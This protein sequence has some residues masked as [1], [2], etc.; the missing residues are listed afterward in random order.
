MVTITDLY[1]FNTQYDEEGNIEI[2]DMCDYPGESKNCFDFFK[3]LELYNIYK[4]G[5]DFPINLKH[6]S[7]T[8]TPDDE[9]TLKKYY[10]IDGLK[11]VLEENISKLKDTTTFFKVEISFPL[12]SLYPNL[13]FHFFH[14]L[15]NEGG[16]NILVN[17]ELDMFESILIHYDTNPFTDERIEELNKL[18]NV[19]E[20]QQILF[21]PV[22]LI[23]FN[24][25]GEIM[26]IEQ[27]L[28]AKKTCK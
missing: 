9:E 14:N 25:E 13:I 3:H 7:V 19:A 18:V 23:R 16:M 2:L 15:I 24:E 28:L 12:G 22:E 8:I 11:L 10:C 4:S 17:D 5:I 27:H 21:F 6:W 1:G 20:L 26:V